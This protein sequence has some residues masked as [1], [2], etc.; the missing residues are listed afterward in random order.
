[1]PIAVQPERPVIVF[2]GNCG[3]CQRQIARIRRGDPNAQFEYLPSQSPDL[4]TR[5]PALAGHELSSGLRLVEPRGAIHVGA[6]ATYHIARRLRGWRW[7][8]W[9]YRVPG[10][11]WLARLTYGWIARNRYRFAGRQVCETNAC[12]FDSRQK[13]PQKG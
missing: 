5:F 2:D 8:A 11:N 6:E 10:V 3:F 4:L 12:H 13:S 7:V 1:M 9:L